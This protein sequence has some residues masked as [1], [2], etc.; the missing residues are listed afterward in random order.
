MIHTSQDADRCAMHPRDVY[1]CHNGADETIV[2]GIARRLESD[3][4]WTSWYAERDMPP[5]V[6]NCTDAIAEMVDNSTVFLLLSS[7]GISCSQ[8][9]QIAASQAMALDKKRLELKIT[10]VH[11]RVVEALNLQLHTM[12]NKKGASYKDADFADEG[13]GAAGRVGARALTLFMVAV[14]IFGAYIVVRAFGVTERLQA[15]P[16]VVSQETPPLNIPVRT[17]APTPAP[18]PR[19]E[20][21]IINVEVAVPAE[22]FR[23]M[24]QAAAGDVAAK[25][26]LGHL[27]IQMRDIQ[28]AMYWFKKAAYE[29]HLDATLA[30][31]HIYMEG[32]SWS[33][34]QDFT[35]DR[36]EAFLWF[37][38]A[39]ELGYPGMQN[40]IASQYAR[41][42]AVFAGRYT[43]NEGLEIAEH[44]HVEITPHSHIV[45]GNI[46]TAYT[47][48]LLVLHDYERAMYWYRRAAIQGHAGAQT[49]LGVMYH[50]G[51]GVTANPT[52]AAY[53]YTHAATQGNHVAKSNLGI[54]YIQ[55]QGVTQSYQQA[56]YWF[57]RSAEQNNASAQVNLAWIY[58]N[59]LV[60]DP[61]IEQSF[62]WNHRAAMLGHTT[63]QNNTGLMYM[64]GRG[65]EQCYYQAEYWFRQAAAR[66]CE[67]GIA[68]LAM[69]YEYGMIAE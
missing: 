46:V 43:G 47:R 69:L 30:V 16:P 26:L 13:A 51:Q 38:K 33:W 56:E 3:Y 4:G 40:W 27:Y 53:W 58:E 55:G 57:R 10:S 20:S 31:G 52:Q 34:A 48:A 41:G 39:A 42:N 9:V 60:G 11:D 18:A 37:Y 24:S 19:L 65:V 49:T 68:Y 25:Y 59:G 44:F 67:R 6:H 21:E 54:A 5:G 1:I 14:M 22:Y 28:S 66:N 23:T 8:S 62:Y 35:S 50:F 15:S 32:E 17:P 2:E 45:S 36:V 12:I 63:G 7:S 64:Q 61:N 29:Q